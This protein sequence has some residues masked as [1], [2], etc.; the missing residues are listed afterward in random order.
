MKRLIHVFA[1]PSLPPSAQPRIEGIEFHGP[2]AQG[3]VYTL[4]AS[5]PF[6]IGIVDGYFERVPAVW[7]KEILW[8]LAEGIHVLGAA[9]MGALRAVELEPFGMGGV[10]DVFES[11]RSGALSDDDEVTIVHADESE[12]YRPGSEALVNIRAT[13]A[14]AEREGVV[15]GSHR[16]SLVERMKHTFYPDRSYP[17][18]LSS[19]REIMSRSEFGR[20]R[21]WLGNAANRIDVKRRDALSLV[22]IL[23]DMQNSTTPPKQ[24]GW[25]FHHTDAWE[26]VR[27]QA[28]LERP[29]RSAAGAPIELQSVAKLATDDAKLAEVRDKAQLRALRIE[30]AKRDGFVPTAA[31]IA[32]AAA[33][34]IRRNGWTSETALKTWMDVQALDDVEMERLLRDEACVQWSCRMSGDDP[35]ALLD[36][37]RLAEAS[38]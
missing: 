11:F 26:H 10:G 13:L 17:A 23:A 2:A 24:L 1:G 14:S 6:A 31:D 37:L 5:R 15:S 20:L 35:R 18:I 3:D 25:S 33:A 29:A 30:L 7:H 21:A 36:Y 19:A 22:S 4:V 32:N 9:S 27:R 8:A 38:A 16:K 34:L 28:V 12:G